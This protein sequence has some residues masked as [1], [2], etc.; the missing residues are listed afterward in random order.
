MGRAFVSFFYTGTWGRIKRERVMARPLIFSNQ[1]GNKGAWHE[2]CLKQDKSLLGADTEKV[3]R[4]SCKVVLSRLNS[5]N[6]NEPS[7]QL[8]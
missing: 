4:K 1:K 6:V 8:S 2:D 3:L 5:V 7:D